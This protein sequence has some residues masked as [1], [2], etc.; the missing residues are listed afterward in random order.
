MDTRFFITDVYVPSGAKTIETNLAATVRK[1]VDCI[2]S[3]DAM[4]RLADQ[5]CIEH[6]KL[7]EGNKR[8]KP[9]SI[10]ID[11]EGGDDDRPYLYRHFHIGQVSVA[12]RLVKGEII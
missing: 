2:L 7:I 6:E 4:L 3:Y 9:I 12:F 5:I 11:L 8:L 10:S 1:Y